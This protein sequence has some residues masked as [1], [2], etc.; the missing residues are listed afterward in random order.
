MS[1]FNRIF[2]G[3]FVYFNKFVGFNFNHANN[4]NNVLGDNMFKF[5]FYTFKKMFSLIS[6]PIFVFTPDKVVIHLFY[7]IL[8]PTLLKKKI[9]FKNFKIRKMAKIK[10]QI[11]KFK[12]PNKYHSKKILIKNHEN[13]ENIK[14]IKKN[15]YLD[16]DLDLNKNN[17]SRKNKNISKVM[18]RNK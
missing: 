9:Y 11:L 6:K 4:Y 1:I 2:K 7:Y 13:I 17:L 5:L 15:K 3:S 12:T 16:L 14:N 10:K 8:L 18:K